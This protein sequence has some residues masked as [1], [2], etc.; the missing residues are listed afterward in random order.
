MINKEDYDY[1]KKENYLLLHR[2]N[3]PTSHI[4]A[5]FV[6]LDDYIS[7]NDKDMILHYV[8]QI[9][10]YVFH[11]VTWLLNCMMDYRNNIKISEKIKEDIWSDKIK[12]ALCQKN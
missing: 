10:D 5:L 1:Y 6:K 9:D 7:S 3:T 11:Q 2:A 4:D 8:K 12:E